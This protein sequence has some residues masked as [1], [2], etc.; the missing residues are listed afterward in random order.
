MNSVAARLRAIGATLLAFALA[1]AALAALVEGLERF[2]A[3][4]RLLP[5]SVPDPAG[6]IGLLLAPRYPAL[7]AALFLIVAAAVTLLRSAYLD[8][9]LEIFGDVLL[10]ILAASLGATAG[11]WALLRLLGAAPAL[12]MAQVLPLGVLAALV[13]LVLLIA[14]TRV[15]GNVL[16]RTLAVIVFVLAAPVLLAWVWTL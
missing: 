8:R 10:M 6:W 3:L 9:M 5:G 1:A 4:T 14:P 15:R 16:L 12:D 7:L 2:P 13:F 11:T